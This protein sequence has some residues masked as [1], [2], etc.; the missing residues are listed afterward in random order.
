[1]EQTDNFSFTLDKNTYNTMKNMF[2]RYED[3]LIPKY[4]G[5]SLWRYE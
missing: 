3:T 1:M 2:T 5:T 4:F